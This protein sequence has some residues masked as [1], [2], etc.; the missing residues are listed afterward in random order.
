MIQGKRAELPLFDDA[1]DIPNMICVKNMEVIDF[2]IVR[3]EC[4]KCGTTNTSGTRYCEKC[5][6]DLFVKCGPAVTI[7]VEEP[8]GEENGD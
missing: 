5:G 8:R 3:G 2:G 6:E 4:R 7:S 1:I